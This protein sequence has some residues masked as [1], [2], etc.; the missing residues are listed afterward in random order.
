MFRQQVVKKLRHGLNGQVRTAMTGSAAKDPTAGDISSS[1]PSLSGLT[2]GALDESYKAVQTRIFNGREDKLKESWN[3]LLNKLEEEVARVRKHGNAV[4]PQID[5]SDLKR[6]ATG[7]VTFDEEHQALIRKTGVAIVRNVIPQKEARQWKYDLDEYI[8]NNPVISFPKENPTVFELYWSKPQLAGRS[9]QNSID[10]QKALNNLWHTS[11]T[12]PQMIST[13]SPL[14]YADRLR[15]RQP[16]NSKF[17]LGPHVD[18]GG[19]ER[20]E[21]LEYSKV[22]DKIFEGKWEEFDPFD[23]NHRLTARSDLHQ[24]AG[25]CSM[26]RMFQGWLSMS[27]SGPGQGSLKV[28]PFLKEAASY[29]LLRPFFAPQTAIKSPGANYEITDNNLD[30][31]WEFTGG[32]SCFPNTM[33]G[34]SQEMTHISHPH[35]HL[36]DTMVSIPHMNPGD[37]V[38][39]HCDTIHQVEGE[40]GGMSDASVLY[41]PA[42]PLTE[43][44]LEH[45]VEIRKHFYE[46]APG[47]DFPQNGGIGESKFI[48]VGTVDDI[49]S[50]DGKRAM[51]VGEVPF[52]VNAA[53][54]EGE[55]KMYELAN[56]TLWG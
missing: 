8:K 26:F 1:F 17:S 27:S 22:Y 48:G 55:R 19:I 49:K 56:R 16:G 36:S 20:W 42:C 37:Y 47:P 31:P 6:D 13:N 3:S 52:D 2:V 35:L 30:V 5:V 18:T 34:Y 39:W 4:I 24:Q 32:T 15:I 44:N 14:T 23:Y 28:N 40:H 29:L 10:V 53:Q 33:P 50:T 25:Q 21:D 54:N 46:L 11:S 51:G 38:A 41:I 45:L 9:I 43:S 7:N 12:T